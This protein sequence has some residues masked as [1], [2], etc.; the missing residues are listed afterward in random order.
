MFSYERNPVVAGYFYP[1]SRG[2]LIREIESLFT[3]KLGP[4][5]IP[6]IQ[7]SG[8]R[9]IFGL[10]SPHA[11]Y[12]YSGGVALNGYSR[13]AED[14]LPEVIILIG[15]NH[16]GVGPAISVY[17]RGVWHLPLGDVEV[18]DAFVEE[19]LSVEPYLMGDADAHLYEH[20]IEVQIPFL[21]YIYGRVGKSF[22][23]V[24][25]VM[26]QQTWSAVD[27]LG[28]A[29]SKV[30]EN[31]S[32]ESYI[33]VASSDFSHYEPAN[34]AMEK[35]RLVLDKILSLDPNGLIEAVYSHGVSMCGYGPVSTMLYLGR[36]LGVSKAVLLRYG[37]S[38]DVT[39]D[40]G[41][42]VAYASLMVLWEDVD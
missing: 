23:I 21:Q 40:Y 27:I 26:M 9:R 12:M 3:S 1:S 20:S 34:V 6:D 18:D 7:V 13:L 16:S 31:Y 10:V 38:G 42:V 36:S 41:S 15:P 14:G 17:P 11:G 24:P 5:S 32:R 2:A 25:I 22:K 39:G 35:D 30:L 4:G 29:L 37:S 19:L 8:P 28:S 33:L